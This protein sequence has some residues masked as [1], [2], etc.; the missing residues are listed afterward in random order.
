MAISIVRARR[1]KQLLDASDVRYTIIDARAQDDYEAGHIPGAIGMGWEDWCAR[2]PADAS[3][4]LFEPGYWGVLDSPGCASFRR[5]LAMTGITLTTALLVYGDGRCSAGREG[6]IAWMM[7]YLGAREVAI[8]DGGWCGWLEGGGDGEP[9]ECVP[10]A[11]F[12]KIGCNPQG[13]LARE[14]LRGV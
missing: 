14:A 1:L 8:L 6:R 3:S 2:P 9:A 10:Q 4:A 11:G 12:R 7:L 13:R 5:R